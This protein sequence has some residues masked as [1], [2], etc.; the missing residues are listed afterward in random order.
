MQQLT[1]EEME[2]NMETFNEI[3]FYATEMPP[4]V[5]PLETEDLSKM[6]DVE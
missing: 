4:E 1:S 3:L 2:A 6:E 5:V